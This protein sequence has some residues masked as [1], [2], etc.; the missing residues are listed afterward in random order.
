MNKL[1]TINMVL[2]TALF[3]LPLVNSALAQTVHHWETIVYAADSWSYFVGTSQPPADWY[4]LG[5]IDISWAEGPGGIG[6]GDGDDA[7]EIEST[8]SLYMRIKFSILDTAV[9]SKAVFNMDYDDAFVAYL[10]GMEIARSNI[11]TPGDHPDYDQT[12]TGLHEATMYVGG[13]PEYYYLTTRQTS[14]LLIPGD[15]VLAVQVH[16][17]SITSSDLS[18][19]PFFSLGIKDTSNNYRP[20]PDWFNAPVDFVASKLPIIVIDTD[21]QQILDEPKIPAT[22]GIIYSGEGLINNVSDPFNNYDG[23]I[24]I[25]FR[26]QS[27]QS[28]PKKSYGLET[29]DGDGENLNVSILGLPEENDWVLYGPYSDKTLLRNTLSF[30]MAQ[31]LGQYASRTVFCELVL[32]NDYQGLYVLMEKI[33]RDKNRVDI[34]KLN[35]EDINGDGLTGGYIIKCDKP[36]NTGWQV[37]VDPPGDFGKVYY[38]YHYPKQEDIVPEQEAYIQN[39]IFEFESCLVSDNFA[40]PV[41]GYAKYIDINSFVDHFLLQEFTKEIDSYRFS[42]Y[43]YKMKDSNGGKLHAGPVWD[44]NLAYGNFGEGVWEEPWTTKEWNAEIPAWS[45]VFWFDR[46]LEDYNFQNKLKTRWIQIREGFFSNE[47]ILA[48]LDQ[49]ALKIEDARIRNFDRWPVIGEYVWPNYYIGNS[50]E[51][52]ITWLKNWIIARLDW[53]DTN[54]PGEITSIFIGSENDDESEDIPVQPFPNPFNSSSKIVY[55]IDKPGRVSISIF[56][57]LGRHIITDAFYASAKG[58]FAF[59]WD[60]TG[61]TGNKVASSVYFYVVKSDNLVILK[62]KFVKID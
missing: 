56:D 23:Y 60:G 27:A 57:A 32:N 40:D 41:D 9:I 22:M 26:G 4:T 44:F 6:Y 55:K 7:T 58:T 45:R 20:V 43:I 18:S 10:N 38:Q 24:G 14:D 2:I 48:Y 39:F 16:N 3:F 31:Q 30:Y 25:E 49:T 17:E 50:Y 19:I 62:G 35:P 28:Y 34:D 46:M 13:S 37:D 33:K 61:N 11:G 15:N 8:I 5:F 53:M 29:R 47:N 59:T 42:Y 1:T 52:E 36:Y 54:M 51:E 21:G 12:S